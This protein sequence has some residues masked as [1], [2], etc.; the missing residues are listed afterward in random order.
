MI[1]DENI[2]EHRPYPSEENLDDLEEQFVALRGNLFASLAT[3]PR[4][5]VTR[6]SRAR[7]PRRESLLSSGLASMSCT[8]RA[9]VISSWWDSRD[10]VI[11]IFIC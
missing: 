1:D 6:V 7:V 5:C 4:L 8:R 2:N 3:S 9:R 11:V 10:L